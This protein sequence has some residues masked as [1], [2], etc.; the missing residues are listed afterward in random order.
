MSKAKTKKKAA[1][2]RRNEPVSLDG[3]VELFKSGRI[4]GGK[5]SHEKWLAELKLKR[6][7]RNTSGSSD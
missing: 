2:A 7:L 4:P 6:D 3:V 5:A 1:A